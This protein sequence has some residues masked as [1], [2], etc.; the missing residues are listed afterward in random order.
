MSEKYLNFRS[1]DMKIYF[2]VAEDDY[3]LK[4]NKLD[5]GRLSLVGQD[6]KNIYLKFHAIPRMYS[7]LYF[8]YLYF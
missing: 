4:R 5:V 8:S 7:E 6:M 2:F 3:F 1:L